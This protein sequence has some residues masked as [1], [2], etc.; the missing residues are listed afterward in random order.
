M[1]PHRVRTPVACSSATGRGPR[2]SACEIDQRSSQT[3]SLKKNSPAPLGAT[4]PPRQSNA[5]RSQASSNRSTPP[6]TPTSR[7][8]PLS[9]GSGSTHACQ[10]RYT[11][12]RRCMA[13]TRCTGSRSRCLRGVRNSPTAS[14]SRNRLRLLRAGRAHGHSV[15]GAGGPGTLH[16]LGLRYRIEAPP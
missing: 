8:A 12:R 2:G 9:T 11:G 15:P 7:A 13:C 10:M 6:T 5:G 1:R 14:A 3:R 4:M 16:P